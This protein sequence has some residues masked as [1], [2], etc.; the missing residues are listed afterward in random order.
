MCQIASLLQNTSENDHIKYVAFI[1]HTHLH[2]LECHINGINKEHRFLY[3]KKTTLKKKVRRICFFSIPQIFKGTGLC[4]VGFLF[5]GKCNNLLELLA[6]FLNT[7]RKKEDTEGKTLENWSVTSK[8]ARKAHIL[9]VRDMP[10]ILTFWVHPSFQT[11]CEGVPR[12]T[13]SSPNEKSQAEGR[14]SSIIR[15]L[16]GDFPLSS[17]WTSCGFLSHC[18]L[19][20]CPEQISHPQPFGPKSEASLVM[21]PCTKCSDYLLLMSLL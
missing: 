8:A 10:L 20:E 12:V 5:T 7:N 4:Y 14:I 16:L 3:F 17:W 21:Y 11:L 13:Q 9:L 6:N 15:L 1:S 2:K 18:P 19:S